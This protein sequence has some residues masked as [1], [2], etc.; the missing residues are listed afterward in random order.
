MEKCQNHLV[1]IW[2]NGKIKYKMEE[3]ANQRQAAENE[4]TE[5]PTICRSSFSSVDKCKR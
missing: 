2:K 1:S 5:N 4:S 3:V